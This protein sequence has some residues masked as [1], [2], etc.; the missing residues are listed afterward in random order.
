MHGA[1]T[2]IDYKTLRNL[3]CR[4]PKMLDLF[5][6]A[7]QQIYALGQTTDPAHWLPQRLEESIAILKASLSVVVY[8]RDGKRPIE[9]DYQ[10]I[11]GMEYVDGGIHEHSLEQ[12]GLLGK[13]LWCAL[14]TL[15][16][17]T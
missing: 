12:E 14:A 16:K 10:V 11:G 9:M 17:V 8:E 2:D 1:R 4:Y 3:Q 5:R 13:V 7:D 6:A 15:A